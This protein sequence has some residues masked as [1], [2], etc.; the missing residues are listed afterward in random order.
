MFGGS[1]G[2]RFGVD[3]DDRLGV[4]FA[5]VHPLFIELNFYAVNGINRLLG[6]FLSALLPAPRLHL[7]RG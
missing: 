1:N 7:F 2:I 6:V 5:Q 3:P 4:G